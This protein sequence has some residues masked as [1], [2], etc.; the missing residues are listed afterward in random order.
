MLLKR[1]LI[2]GLQALYLYTLAFGIFMTDSLRL[3]APVIF[4]LPLLFFINKPALQFAYY[5]ETGMFIFALLLYYVIGMGDYLSFFAYSITIVTCAFYFNYFVGLNRQRFNISVLLFFSLLLLS[6]LIM[7]LDH[8]DQASIDPLRDLMLDEKVKQSPSGL[9]ITQFTF[10]YQIAA[11]TVFVFVFTC[12]FRQH[13]LIKTLALCVCL[14]CIYLGMNRSAFVSFVL[15]VFLFLLMYYRFKAIFLITASVIIGFTIYTYFLK[16]SLDSKNNIL[17]KNQ[18]KEANDY[19]R[20]G[21]ASEN[22]KVYADYPFG[23]IFYGKDWDEV[24]YKNPVFTFG[25]TSHNAYLMFL[26]YLGPFLGLGLLG[27]IYYRIIRLFRETISH[28]RLK[29]SALLLCLLFSFLA[30]SLNALSHNGWLISADGP[31]LFLYFSIMQGSKIYTMQ[32]DDVPVENA[33]VLV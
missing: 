20:G 14:I 18:A 4:G 11:F 9:A 12:A 5:R 7:V 21:L 3:P 17:A 2:F 32:K 16:D 8:S 30:V 26:T 23:L 25:L 28:I 19:N 6:M 13:F 27:A 29:S 22:L 33:A 31:T 15:A 10:G 24:T 1:I